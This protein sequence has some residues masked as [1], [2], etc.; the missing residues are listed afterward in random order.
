MSESL[1][2]LSLFVTVVEHGGFANSADEL[3][4]TPSAVSKAIARLEEKLG[5]RLFTRSTRSIK[6][7]EP[8]REFYRR[9]LSILTAVNEAEAV[10]SNLGSEPQ[11]DLRVACSD[12][13]A[14]LVIVPM[15]ERFHKTYPRIRVQIIQ[16]DGPM[17]LVHQNYDVA[18]RFE[19]PE[20]KS[21]IATPLVSDPWVICAAPDYLRDHPAPE[22]P[23]DL[24]HHRCLSIFARDRLDDHWGFRGGKRNS[25]R[26]EPVF[27]GIGLV[28]KAAALQG[29]GIARLANFL[30]AEEIRRKRLVPLLADYQITGARQIYIVT[31]DREYVPAKSRVFINALKKYMQ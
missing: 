17:D 29:L 2:N 22:R 1:K 21:L 31:P 18:I 26:V 23:A 8:G 9:A 20:Q 28:V 19:R 7:T 15:L 14:N 25:I 13:F 24:V 12:A 3:G 30:V 4:I 11:G 10:V 16:G 27:S 6:L 5:T